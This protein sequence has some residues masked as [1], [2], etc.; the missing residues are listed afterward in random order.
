MTGS[1]CSF[2]SEL[3]YFRPKGFVVTES[4]FNESLNKAMI[5]EFTCCEGPVR[6]YPK[7]EAKIT[8]SVES[9]YDY[10]TRVKLGGRWVTMHIL[11]W[12]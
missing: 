5:R 2:V 12:K 6:E 7:L 9:L 4:Y 3:C 10:T 8:G 1:N 11:V